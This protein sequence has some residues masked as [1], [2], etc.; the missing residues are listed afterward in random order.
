MPS[1]RKFGSKRKSLKKSIQRKVLK[2]ISKSSFRLGD[3]VRK[4]LR[5]TRSRRPKM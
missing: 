2:S 4:S 3:L 1:R 5:K